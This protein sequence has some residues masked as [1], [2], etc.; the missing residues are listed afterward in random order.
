M[1]AWDWIRCLSGF[2]EYAPVY[3]DREVRCARC[4]RINYDKTIALLDAEIR[5]WD[6]A[7]DESWPPELAEVYVTTIWGEEG[8]ISVSTK[9]N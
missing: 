2:H 5:M 6:K 3:D 1:R 7:Q 8:R 4:N 9:S